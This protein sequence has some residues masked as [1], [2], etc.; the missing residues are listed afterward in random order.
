MI[1]TLVFLFAAAGQGP[2]PKPN[3]D[4]PVCSVPRGEFAD[5]IGPTPLPQVCLERDSLAATFALAGPA[6]G[7][8]VC[9]PVRLS[10]GAP[11]LLVRPAGAR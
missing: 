9:G 4:P 2:A 3:Q 11:V 6:G 10:A 1:A 5:L 8:A 7:A